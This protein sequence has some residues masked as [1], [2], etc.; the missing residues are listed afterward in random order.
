MEKIDINPNKIFLL[1]LKILKNKR[2]KKNE[3]FAMQN[4]IM[5]VFETPTGRVKENPN[6]SEINCLGA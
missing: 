3:S 6:M 4:Q 5:Y 1:I 2:I